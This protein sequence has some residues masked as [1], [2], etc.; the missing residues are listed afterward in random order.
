MLTDTPRFKKSKI[1]KRKPNEVNARYSDSQ[2][3]E[4][5]K[6]YLVIGSNTQVCATL[7]ISLPTFTTWKTQKWW[8]DLIE[9]LRHESSIQLS[10]RLQKIAS[11]SFDL[12][13]DRL[14]HGDFIYDQQTGELRRKPMLG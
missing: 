1:V 12:V 9:D 14:E 3:I 11:K 6:L 8:K 4:A 2:K 10:A 13:E 5:A 7:G